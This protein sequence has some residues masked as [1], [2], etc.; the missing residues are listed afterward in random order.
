MS[1]ESIETAITSTPR[2]PNS[3][4]RLS[5]AISSDEQKKSKI[6]RIEK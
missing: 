3:S 2:L 1:G 6:Q 4:K 5:K